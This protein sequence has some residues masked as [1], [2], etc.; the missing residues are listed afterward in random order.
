MPAVRVLPRWVHRVY[1]QRLGYF[2]LPCASCGDKFG[3]HEWRDRRGHFSSLPVHDKE[4][5]LCPRCTLAG[6]GCRAWGVTVANLGFGTVHI[7]H[8]G[9]DRMDS[10]CRS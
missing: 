6:V 3:G 8:A 4:R 7:G 9:C 1:A 2:W 5:A 10:S